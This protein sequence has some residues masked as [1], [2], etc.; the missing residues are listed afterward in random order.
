[1]WRI[2]LARNWLLSANIK[3]SSCSLAHCN[4]RLKYRHNYRKYK[5]N[6]IDLKCLYLPLVIPSLFFLTS[7]CF[8]LSFLM[9]S[10]LCSS[11]SFGSVLGKKKKGMA[12]STFTPAQIK[13]PIHHAPTQ[14]VSVGVMVRSSVKRYTHFFISLSH[15]FPYKK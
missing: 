13:K 15:Y 2:R 11:P 10:A 7:S 8:S 4:V 3:L 14:R 12:V 9:I 6:Y 5:V 1:M